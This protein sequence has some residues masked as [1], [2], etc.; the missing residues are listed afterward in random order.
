MVSET[1][2]Y[3]D[4]VALE[5]EALKASAAGQF[6]AAQQAHGRALALARDWARPRL[7]AVLFLRLGEAFEGAGDIQRAVQSYE[8]GFIALAE[9]AQLDYA[10]IQG[11]LEEFGRVSKGFNWSDVLAM[12]TPDLY[13][14]STARKLKTAEA[15]PLLAVKLLVNSG[16]AY[17]RQPQET[18][19]LSR[20]EQALRMPEIVEAPELQAHVLMHIGFIRRRFGETDVA[21]ESQK[22]IEAAGAACAGCGAA[23]GAGSFGGHLP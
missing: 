17:L 23:A 8:Q 5:Q 15:D 13:R 6:R 19:A 2:L 12:P 16:N 22:G 4:I 21:E 9:D 10:L 7:K 11:V 3:R 1:D 20:Y 14:P 18:P